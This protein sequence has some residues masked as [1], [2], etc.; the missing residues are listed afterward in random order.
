M[1]ENGQSRNTRTQNKIAGVNIQD[2]SLPSSVEKLR[3]AHISDAY[4]VE[5]LSNDLEEAREQLAESSES[6]TEALLAEAPVWDDIGNPPVV[7]FT[8]RMG[9][10][11]YGY[12]AIGVL[13]D[14]GNTIFYTTAAKEKDKVLTWEQ[15]V[16]LMG[17]FAATIRLLSGEF[18]SARYDKE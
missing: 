8:K 18:P 15:L 1:E 11:A 3:L 14:A 7:Q 5:V 2:S 10:K 13:D 6:Y 12:A 17:K 16:N 4:H 9:G